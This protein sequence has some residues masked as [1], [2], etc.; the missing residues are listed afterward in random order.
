MPPRLDY[1]EIE[2]NLWLNI[3]TTNAARHLKLGMD[4]RVLCNDGV[5]VLYFWRNKG[6]VLFNKGWQLELDNI[7]MVTI[8]MGPLKK[9]CKNEKC[10]KLVLYLN[11][12]LEII[13]N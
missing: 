10:L 12:L 5:C 8:W 1:T 2:I 13:I 7:E 3:V 11:I 9:G 4:L 6:A